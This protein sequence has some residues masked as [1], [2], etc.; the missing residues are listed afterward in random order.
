MH[1]NS[2]S[3]FRPPHFCFPPPDLHN[4]AP[5]RYIPPFNHC[6]PLDTSSLQRH[7]FNQIF[8]MRGSL[9]PCQLFTDGSPLRCPSSNQMSPLHGSLM[10][11]H[12]CNRHGSPIRFSLNPISPR[13]VSS[14]QQT[15][16]YHLPLD[17]SSSSPHHTHNQRLPL[18]VTSSPHH[19]N[20][21]HLP[22]IVSS[23]HHMYNRRPLNVSSTTHDTHNQRLSLDRSPLQRPVVVLAHDNRHIPWQPDV[24]QA[25]VP[26]RQLYMPQQQGEP[27]SSHSMD[28]G[29][30]VQPQ[31]Q[32]QP[33][34]IPLS[35]AT[36][37]TPHNQELFSF[38]K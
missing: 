33:S 23:S 16:N 30:A 10:Q 36:S 11:N 28:T 31:Q 37:G 20:N 25:T 9:M 17:G 4:T 5:L 7:A 18:F 13:H 12:T 35:V 2:Q 26:Q 14:P 8:R 6:F 1:A 38:S 3:S 29:M 19:I 15:F 21:Q 34:L 32:Q 27:A 22:L 24:R